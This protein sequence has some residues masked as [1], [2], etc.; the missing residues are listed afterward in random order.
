MYAI[1]VHIRNKIF[2]NLYLFSYFK[3]ENNIVYKLE[4]ARHRMSLFA[5]RFASVRFW[6]SNC[7]KNKIFSINIL[8]GKTI[9]M[10]IAETCLDGRY[11]SIA[12]CFA[13]LPIDAKR[14]TAETARS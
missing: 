10:S 6:N 8:R 13:I 7:I 1:Q 14:F 2:T 9:E 12:E 3:V 5:S 4:F 11:T